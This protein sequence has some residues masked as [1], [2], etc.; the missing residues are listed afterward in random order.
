MGSTLTP[1]PPDI[2][3]DSSVLFA[4]CLS[5]AGSARDLIS[6]AKLGR[7]SLVVSSVVWDET[8]RNLELKSPEALPFLHMLDAL[9]LARSVQPVDT[10][11]A[12][13]AQIIELKDAP[14]V[15]GAVTARANFLA[16]YDRKHLLR[17]ATIIQTRY[18][19]IVTTPDVIVARL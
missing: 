9:Q 4:G 1:L 15:A 5:S 16:T 3:V 8:E 10:L 11:V 13:V 2:F 17:Q 19:I 6:Q 12:E 18:G 14:I 7:A